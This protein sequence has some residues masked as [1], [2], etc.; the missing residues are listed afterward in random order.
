MATDQNENKPTIERGS[1]G[2]CGVLE[3]GR[4]DGLGKVGGGS[5]ESGVTTPPGPR[6]YEYDQLPKGH[7]RG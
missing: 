3:Q 1:H 5:E 7:T 2:D 4:P 6:S